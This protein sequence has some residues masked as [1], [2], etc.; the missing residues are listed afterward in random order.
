[1]EKLDKSLSA[2]FG[3]E[4]MNVTVIEEDGTVIPEADND[5]AKVEIDA[6]TV[7]SNMYSLMQKGSDALEYA[8]EIAKQGESPRGFEV[9]ATMMKT[10]SDINLQL[11]DSHDKKQRLSKKQESKEQPTKVVNNAIVFSSSTKELNQL[12]NSMKKENE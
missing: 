6:D 1:M 4:P 11:L 7:R 8:I 9:V 3:T 2:V 10:L 12:L 5:A